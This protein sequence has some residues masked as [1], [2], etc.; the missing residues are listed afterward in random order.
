MDMLE[1]KQHSMPHILKGST[2]TLLSV[3]QV[4]N[5]H[6]ISNKDNSSNRSVTEIHIIHR[7]AK[8]KNKSCRRPLTCKPS[9]EGKKTIAWSSDNNTY[10]NSVELPVA[11]TNSSSCRQKCK[12]CHRPKTSIVSKHAKSEGCLTVNTSVIRHDVTHKKSPKLHRRLGL[13]QSHGDTCEFQHYEAT[14]GDSVYL[15]WKA[16][17]LARAKSAR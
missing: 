2:C 11:I 15:Q 8:T 5:S 3:S 12:S 14:T 6:A 4:S 13:Q 10:G 16:K 17:H 1:V 9:F 7:K